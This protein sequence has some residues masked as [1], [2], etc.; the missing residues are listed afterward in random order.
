MQKKKCE[1]AANYVKISRLLFS[2]FFPSLLSMLFFPSLSRL[3][4]A[5][6]T[7]LLKKKSSFRGSK[8]Y[9]DFFS[10]SF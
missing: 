7:K 1:A 5:V 10:T 8:N 3:P 9:A 4:T 2:V 6:C